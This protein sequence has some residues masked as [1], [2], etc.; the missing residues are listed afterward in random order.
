MQLSSEARV[1]VVVVLA[2]LIFISIII[3]IGAIRMDSGRYMRYYAYA[4]DSV[5]LSRKS[6]IKIAGV[7]VGYIDSITLESDRAAPV[8]LNLMIAKEFTLY[9]DARIMI[10]Q[11]GMLGPKYIEVMPGTPGQPRIVMNGTFARA[12]EQMRS[13]DDIY[14]K[15]DTFA[16]QIA[17]L[18]SALTAMSMKGSGVLDIIGQASMHIAS[19]S[20]TLDTALDHSVHKLDDFFQMA[21]AIIRT[22]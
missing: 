18:S 10:R 4:S 13:F 11:D 9:A 17:Q 15:F 19:M 8:E 1:G 14:A 21:D 7:R 12:C 22:L 16:V 6:E 20:A 3:W 2:T 5:G